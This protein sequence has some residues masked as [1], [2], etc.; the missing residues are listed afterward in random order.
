MI[1]LDNSSHFLFRMCLIIAILIQILILFE[2]NDVKFERNKKDFPFLLN[3]KMKNALIN[4]NNMISKNS[5]IFVTGAY[6]SGKSY[7]SKR[8]MRKRIRKCYF[9]ID[10]NIDYLNSLVNI[11]IS[12]D[13]Y[14]FRKSY[15]CKFDETSKF[16]NKLIHMNF[17]SSTFQYNLECAR[18]LTNLIQEVG[19]LSKISIYIH[20]E[21]IMDEPSNQLCELENK[22][23]DSILVENLNY[24]KMSL[25]L[26]TSNYDL[27]FSKTESSYLIVT[28]PIDNYV[29]RIA[30]DL[31]YFSRNEAKELY[32]YFKGHGG[33]VARIIRNIHKG[34]Q[35]NE[36]LSGYKEILKKNVD[37]ILSQ[38]Q[39]LHYNSNTIYQKICNSSSL[40]LKY[41]E[42]YQF[43]KFLSTGYMYIKE[44]GK[45][46]FA[47]PYI[48]ALFCQSKYINSKSVR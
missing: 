30:N 44:T 22:T 41:S 36:S 17:N 13:E 7:L 14:Y 45:I 40:S 5:V 24:N 35:F 4:S 9:P 43:D 1:Q 33:S 46:K 12:D 31:N 32:K 23:F 11:K 6:E 47:N 34:S 27:I 19:K 21:N 26:E 25:V 48:K 42:D 37:Y 38:S 28:S 20:G 2:E 10:I 18:K 3:D 39:D 29:Y 15:S 16:F 8:I